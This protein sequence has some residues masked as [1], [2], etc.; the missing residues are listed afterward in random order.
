MNLAVISIPHQLL[1]VFNERQEA[2]FECA[3]N[4]AKNGVGCLQNSGCTPLGQHYVRARIGEG[5]S[6]YAVLTGRRPTGE[7]WSQALMDAYPQ[8]DWILGRILW[9]CGLESGINRGGQVDTF[10]RYI[11]IH[12]SPAWS[13]E[14]P[15][16][17]HGCVRVQPEDMLSVYQLL[18]YGARVS[19]ET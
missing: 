6:P 5:L 17:S 15:P 13:S 14:M 18:P 3:V 9:L 8:R 10:R 1:T 11:Y 7:E 12:G 16:S 2:L 4:T 19:I